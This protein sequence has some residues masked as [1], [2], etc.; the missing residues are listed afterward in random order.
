MPPGRSPV[1]ERADVLRT[2]GASRKFTD[3]AVPDAVAPRGA[4]RRPVRPERRQ[5]PAMAGRRRR[6]TPPFAAELAELMQPVWDEYVAHGAAG[7]TPF[8]AVDDAPPPDDVA[9]APNDLLAAIDSVPVVLVV[10]ADLHQIALMDA[11]PRAA[12]ADRRGVD[13]PVLLEHPAGRQP[14]GLGGVMTTF[15][16]RVEP[17]A[18]RARRPARAPRPG[19]DDLP[20]RARTPGHA[21]ASG[22]RRDVRH[23]R[24]LRRPAVPRLMASLAPK[25]PLTRLGRARPA[26]A[27]TLAA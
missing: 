16:S 9:H 12:A 23:R 15:L 17:D 11:P 10:A 3:E 26:W 6:V 22:A 14:R 13:L 20:R 1:N 8:N 27:L 5:P 4:R 19:G 7:R 25:T 2:T 24:P 18:A 21:A